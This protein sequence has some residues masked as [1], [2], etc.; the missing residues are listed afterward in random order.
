MVRTWAKAKNSAPTMRPRRGPIPRTQAVVAKPRN[1]ISSPNGATRAPATN[2]RTNPTIVPVGG[3][4]L[5][6][7]TGKMAS[8]MLATTAVTRMTGTAHSA[9]PA[10]RITARRSSARMPIA[11]QSRA[12]VSTTSSRTSPM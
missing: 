5:V 9:P 2:D 7:V 3:S 10:I 1:R 6:G 4:G 8:R 12:P 11:R